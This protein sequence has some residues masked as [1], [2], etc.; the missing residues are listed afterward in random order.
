LI[1]TEE[2]AASWNVAH[3]RG[4]RWRRRAAALTVFLLV[5]TLGVLIPVVASTSEAAQ[6]SDADDLSTCRLGAAASNLSEGFPRPAEAA[7]ST[8]ELRA[9][10]LFVDFS[11][12]PA[13]AESLAAAKANLLDGVGYLNTLSGGALRI[14]TDVTDRW[15]RM[16]RPSTGYPF[17][18]GISFQEHIDYINDAITAADPLIDFAGVDLVWISA[19]KSA[20]SI[21]YSPTTNHL[22]R[23]VDGTVIRHAITFGYDQWFWGPLVLA[24]ETGHVLGLPDL[25]EYEPPSGDAHARVGGFDLMGNIA[26]VAPELMAWH[27]WMLGWLPEERIT[28]LP[29]TPT[30]IRLTPFQWNDG[31]ALG[32]IPLDA[33][34]AVLL[35]ARF[36]LR[37]DRDLQTPGVLISIVDTTVASGEGPISVQDTVPTSS[38]LD[39]AALTANRSW[40][41]TGTD[42]TITVASASATGFDV[43]IAGSA[44]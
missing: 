28:C 42:L 5:G 36:P 15:I 33:H 7:P 31:T 37:Y 14:E 30:A 16:P 44:G 20:P 10:M 11:D 40:T 26:G 12:H 17:A 1:T 6:S 8:G 22:L 39:D 25:Y 29:A 34:R 19:S 3:S 43:Q 9:I 35:E 4:G 18:R 41:V 38:T 32:I 24:H 2:Q 23:T 27:Q 21:S 13:S